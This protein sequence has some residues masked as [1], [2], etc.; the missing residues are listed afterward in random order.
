MEEQQHKPAVRVKKGDTFLMANLTRD[1][2]ERVRVLDV[3]YPVFSDTSCT[4][5]VYYLIMSTGKKKVERLSYFECSIHPIG[6]HDGD[7]G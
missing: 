1:K 4:P 7:I 2:L 6:D 3:L 5:K